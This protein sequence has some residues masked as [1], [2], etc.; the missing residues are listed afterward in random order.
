M[1]LKNT[2]ALFFCIFNILLSLVIVLIYMSGYIFYSNHFINKTSINNIDI[3]NK[4]VSEAKT[5]IMNLIGEYSLEVLDRTCINEVIYGKDFRLEYNVDEI[6]KEIKNNQNVKLWFVEMFKVKNI[7]ISD[8]VTYDEELLREKYEKLEI[9]N[10]TNI[11]EPKNA[12]FIYENN[13]FNVKGHVDGNKVKKDIFYSFIVKSIKSGEKTIDIENVNCYEEPKF[14]ID[15]KEALKVKKQL[16]RIIQTEVNYIYS[17]GQYVLDKA[18]IHKWLSVDN[19]YNININE[20]EI[21]KFLV[22][23]NKN[24]NTVGMEREFITSLDKRIKIFGGDY[25]T[26]IDIRKEKSALI[27][28][29]NSGE[30]VSREP[31]FAQKAFV[32]GDDDIGNT[33]VE[34]NLT[35]QYVWFYKNGELLVE[36]N[37]VS[38]NEARGNKTPSGVYSLKFKQKDAVLKGE[39]YESKVKYWMPFNGGIGIHDA[40]WRGSFGGNI[41]KNN[42][43]HGCVN[44]PI[45]VAKGI[46]DEIEPGTPI[47]CYRVDITN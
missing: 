8:Y 18:I 41:Y 30:K 17:K 3:S 25:G 9:F 34:I 23:L 1:R 33:Y 44:T 4:N 16:N 14:K 31:I 27:E 36:G 43:S 10:N 38:G 11:T 7:D 12:E 35:K 22:D 46:F 5:E 26:T 39:D 21:I 28:I 42:G 15:T 24:Y 45:Y 32:D 19:N 13:R 2:N 29:I 20:K 47:I 37:I 40:S 6:I